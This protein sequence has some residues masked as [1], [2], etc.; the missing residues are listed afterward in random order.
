M[1]TNSWKESLKR[2]EEKRRE[3]LE[4]PGRRCHDKNTKIH[5]KE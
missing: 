1:R 4:H 3:D 2:R 5:L